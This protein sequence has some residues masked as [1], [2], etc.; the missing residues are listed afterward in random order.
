MNKNKITLNVLADIT[1]KINSGGYEAPSNN[2]LVIFNGTNTSLDSRIDEITKLK[3]SGL[4]LSIGFS[5]MAE[6]IMDTEEIVNTLNPRRIY[7]EEDIF[8]LENIV[9]EHSKL[10]MPNITMNTLSKVALG[11]VDSFASNILWTYFYK[12]KNVYL[13]FSSVRSYLGSPSENKVINSIIDNHIGTLI[14]MGAMEI[15]SGNY[16]EKVMG[17]KPK[18]L[19]EEKGPKKGNID[20]SGEFKKVITERDLLNLSKDI[21]SLNLPKGTILTPLAK[22][23]AGELGIKVEIER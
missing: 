14:N 10:I 20:T 3:D 2:V 23:R 1:R 19:A 18:T 21:K 11:M 12:G 8:D 9:E 15:N 17:E 4:G 22:D 7:R 13:D 16:L 6:G 5:L